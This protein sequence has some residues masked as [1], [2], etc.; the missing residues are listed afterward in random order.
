MLIGQKPYWWRCEA[1]CGFPII[2][3][4]PYDVNPVPIPGSVIDGSVL[5][6][7]SSGYWD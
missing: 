5:L 6:L 1:D 3:A 7:G 2:V 4:L